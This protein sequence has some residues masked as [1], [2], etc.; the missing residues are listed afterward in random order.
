MEVAQPAALRDGGRGPLLPY[1]GVGGL[2]IAGPG[3]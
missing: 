2:L 3:R 1:Y